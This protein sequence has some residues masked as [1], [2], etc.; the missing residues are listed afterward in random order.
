VAGTYSLGEAI[1][2]L[3]PDLSKFEDET[4]AKVKPAARKAGEKAGHEMGSGITDTIKG[5]A[6]AIGGVLATVGLID[7]LKESKKAADEQA[8]AIRVTEAVL[9][10]TGGAAGVTGE[11]I[12]RL[13]TRL[14]EMTGVQD[15]VIRSGANVLL[16]FTGIRNEA[17]KGNDVFDQTLS[18]SQD[19]SAALHQDL[20][21]SVIQL[22]KALNDPITGM[23]TLRR[24]GVS[25]TA[26]QIQQAQAMQKSGNL[27]GAQ[28]L[29]LAELTKEF[30][31]AAAAASTPAER[32]KA[33]WDA[34]KAEIGSQVLPAIYKIIDVFAS[35]LFPLLNDKVLPLIRGVADE[36]THGFQHG[37][38]STRGWQGAMQQVGAIARTVYDD[39]L[40]FVRGLTDS[41][42]QSTNAFGKFGAFIRS[43]V[44][45]A[46]T[47]FGEVI[48]TTV[49]WLNQHRAVLLTVVG[50]VGTLIAIDRA[51]AAVL[52][53]KNFQ[54]A[55]YA[56]KWAI[57]RGA[58]LL[59]TA[60][61]W[62][63]N[64]AAAANPIGL[65]VLA[66]AALVV[67]IIYAYNH[68][69]GFRNFVL[70]VWA[71]I[72]SVSSSVGAWFTGPFLNFFKDIGAWFSGPFLTP[73]K[74]IGAWFSGPFIGF[75]K[76]IGA[77]FT[78]PFLVPFQ[79]VW[80]Y[81]RGP[82]AT[83][84]G[85][86]RA[87]V[88][89]AVDIIL[90]EIKIMMAIFQALGAAAVW[91]WQHALLPAWHGIEDAVKLGYATVHPLIQLLIDIA[92]RF[93]AGVVDMA[94]VIVRGWQVLWGGVNR[95]YND[96]IAIFKPLINWAQQSIP[97]AFHAMVDAALRFWQNMWGGVNRAYNDL[98]NI[99]RPLINW[100]QHAIPD[101]FK[102]MSDAV[103]RHWSDIKALASAPIHFMINT[104]VNSGII[105]TF[106][107]I[108]GF[109]HVPT[110]AHVPVPFAAGGQVPGQ[111]S[112]TDNQ[113]A[114]VAS[115]EYIMPTDKTAKYLPWLISMHK[116]DFPGYAGGGL[117]GDLVGLFQSPLSWISKAVS[118][119]GFSQ[120]GDSNIV[121]L[122]KGMGKTA[123]EAMTARVKTLMS[124]LFTS[125]GG[126]GG[127]GTPAGG[128]LGSWIA[129][130]IALT[131]V[132]A[133]WAGPLSVLIH[134]ESGGNPRSI[135]LTDINAQHGDPS[136]GLMQTIGATFNRYRLPGLSADI[137]DPISNIVAG[138]RYILARYGTIFNVQQANP[139]LPPR[140]YS[141]GGLVSRF[142]MDSGYGVLRPGANLVDNGTGG[143]EPI[144]AVGRG[145][146]PGP[147]WEQLER[148]IEAVL[149]LPGGVG[150]EINSTGRSMLRIA[151]AR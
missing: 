71:D 36:L 114:M 78:G 95:T 30:G 28:K 74:A 70:G 9:K 113:L 10:S 66:L 128:A 150:K 1:L 146:T 82:F 21:S 52:A 111:P 141:G 108:A 105:D 54:L 144:A 137:Y 29:I 83:V 99:F 11:D 125:G 81:L 100:A 116:G 3:R 19:V 20:Q 107:R 98:I 145:R 63:W 118:F 119:A 109:F 103:G 40:A 80:S 59:A 101:A 75:F 12:E 17:G 90:I 87:A 86:I 131:G 138:I 55:E 102:T 42:Q 48:A 27:M 136:R 37:A 151:R 92:K 130:A 104:V 62:L 49:R 140:G 117:V 120:F 65:V 25:F 38:E 60:A 68:F 85:L 133:S 126:G 143:L 129:S 79:V 16:T 115:G 41:G 88:Q 57:V 5:F 26:S 72:K 22:G 53:I 44:L 121:Q 147:T 7:F 39:V 96:L 123:L 67:G 14:S 32:A 148:L 47:Q 18:V 64:A 51:H 24:V 91:L 135:N 61:Q 112:R 110:V 77:F 122:A 69:A 31:G 8:Q 97:N 76:A 134:R 6:G 132:P 43:D 56:A 89:I 23:T 34:F 58:Q 13:S 124:S 84:F 45:P 73:F 46:V 106:N 142:S 33:A 50:V 2:R 149:E 15:D 94:N 139:N 4:T 93:G 35:T 127:A